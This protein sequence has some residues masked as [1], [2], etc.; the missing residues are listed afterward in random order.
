LTTLC[1]STVSTT[2]E[3]KELIQKVLGDDKSDDVQRIRITCEAAF[4]DAENKERVWNIL[5]EENS[6]HTVYQ[7]EAMMSGFK[8]GGQELMAPYA[9]K[10]YDALVNLSKK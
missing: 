7:R 6:T 8:A 10:Y 5:I 4:A 9:D 2:D 3:K 1:K